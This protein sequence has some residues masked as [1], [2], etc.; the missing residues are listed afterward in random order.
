MNK[1][2][3]RSVLMISVKEAKLREKKR[4]LKESYV[5]SRKLQNYLCEER[6]HTLFVCLALGKTGGEE[7]ENKEGE[8]CQG[9]RGDDVGKVIGMS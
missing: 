7:R 6:K 1:E 3:L 2:T 4:P 8:A 5:N 9:K